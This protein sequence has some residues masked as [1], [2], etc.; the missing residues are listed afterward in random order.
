MNWTELNWP[1]QVDP[2]TRRVLLVTRSWL[3]AVRELGLRSVQFI[4]CE[5]ADAAQGHV[6]DDDEEAARHQRRCWTDETRGGIDTESRRQD[7]TRRRQVVDNDVAKWRRD[8]S[9][10]WHRSVHCVLLIG[11]KVKKPFIKRRTQLSMNQR[12]LAAKGCS[13]RIRTDEFWDVFG[14]SLRF[15]MNEW[16]KSR[17]CRS[18][19]LQH[20]ISESQSTD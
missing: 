11:N 10:I 5:H 8:W 19:A 20:E 4:C 14:I 18:M 2:V 16:R 13:K 7:K 3:A 17:N 12:R 9:V 15:Q 6:A 1:A